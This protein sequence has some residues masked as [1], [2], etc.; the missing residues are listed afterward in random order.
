MLLKSRIEYNFK[1]EF[2]NLTQIFK[3]YGFIKTM[4]SYNKDEVKYITDIDLQFTLNNKYHRDFEGFYESISSILSNFE[5]FF[6][7]NKQTHLIF[8]A[9]K[10]LEMDYNKMASN[11]Y[12]NSNNTINTINK[13]IYNLTELIKDKK[14]MKK[15]YNTESVIKINM[16]YNFNNGEYYIPIDLIII[17]SNKLSSDLNNVKTCVLYKTNI[18][19][20]NYLKSLKN[21]KGCIFILDRL[22]V[23]N[24]PS[25]LIIDK[26]KLSSHKRDPTLKSIFKTKKHLL[27]LQPKTKKHKV[28]NKLSQININ[29]KQHTQNKQNKQHTQKLTK[30]DKLLRKQIKSHQLSIKDKKQYTKDL[31]QIF[32]DIDKILIKNYYIYSIFNYADNINKIINLPQSVFVNLYND[33]NIIKLQTSLQK[34]VSIILKQRALLGLNYKDYKILNTTYKLNININNY[35]KKIKNILN[36]LEN[37][38]KRYQESFKSLSESYYNKYITI[39]NNVL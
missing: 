11:I 26:P 2:Y 30:Y 3:K 22:N 19:K 36:Q 9:V 17:K 15:I 21:I 32:I 7:N 14:Y 39:S 13:K 38:K 18:K 28:S 5:I 34:I 23:I 10:V 12:D 31:T 4:G 6:K 20:Q 25:N 37:I 27:Q 29:H 24:I 35:N 33:S 16:F 8:E 1:K